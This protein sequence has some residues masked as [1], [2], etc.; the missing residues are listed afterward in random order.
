M[1][2]AMVIRGP[3]SWAYIYIFLGFVLSIEGTAIGMIDTV[4]WLNRLL[5]FGVLLVVSCW[6]FLFNGWFQNKLI[7]MKN[8]YESKAR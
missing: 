3:D 2:D 4:W 8:Q 7:G 6:L 1:V 5:G